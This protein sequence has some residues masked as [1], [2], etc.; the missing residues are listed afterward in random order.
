MFLKTQNLTNS[1]CIMWMYENL[2]SYFIWKLKF[3]E[4]NIQGGIVVLAGDFFQCLSCPWLLQV[5]IILS[6]HSFISHWWNA[7]PKS[8]KL[9]FKWAKIY[10]LPEQV[11]IGLRPPVWI[12][13]DKVTFFD[14]IEFGVVRL[15]KSNQKVASTLICN[16]QRLLEAA[17][18]SI[19]K[20]QP[21]YN[22]MS[23]FDWVSVINLIY[24]A[25]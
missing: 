16:L 11:K 13:P 12:L 19:S 20:Y 25:N 4:S 8:I 5:Q 22:F 7:P 1:Y 3:R 23:Y 9:S 10:F 6:N 15:C 14:K 24:R 17:L 18:Y 2:L 21:N